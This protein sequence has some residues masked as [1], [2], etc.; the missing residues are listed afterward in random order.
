MRHHDTPPPRT[1]GEGDAILQ[2]IAS[3][4]DTITPG[5][6]DILFP[7]AGGNTPE[8]SSDEASAT[9]VAIQRGADQFH[10]ETMSEFWT[11]VGLM[12]VGALIVVG[13]LDWVRRLIRS[14]RDV[15]CCAQSRA[16]NCRYQP[17]RD[18][19]RHKRHKRHKRM[20]IINLGA[21]W[22]EVEA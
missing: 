6:L 8:W 1:S 3:G 11:A 5:T 20:N 7:L 18:V 10:A 2:E 14:R 15:K 4:A 12:V 22:K 17:H 21:I 13:T 19:P 9:A 16:S